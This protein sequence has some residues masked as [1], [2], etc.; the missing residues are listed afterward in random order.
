MF[1]SLFAAA[2]VA[3]VAISVSAPAEAKTR[4]DLYLGGGPGYYE[5]SYPVY[6][7]PVYRP[8]PP[9]YYDDEP[10]Y[11]GISCDEGREAVSESGFRR[12]RALSCDGRRYTYRAR[13]H[14]N[15]YIVTVS[16]RS[17]DIV[18]VREAY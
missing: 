9:R 14:G 10:R 1:K 13:R 11:Y 15:L 8:H 7:E 16:R 4:I 17:G 12:V 6:D 5:P 3:A 18:S 2:A